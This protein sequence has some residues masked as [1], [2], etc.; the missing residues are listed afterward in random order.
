[1]TEHAAC[2]IHYLSLKCRNL[3]MRAGY[4]FTLFYFPVYFLGCEGRIST[5]LTIV[6]AGIFST[7]ATAS[8]TSSAPTFHELSADFGLSASPENSVFTLPGIIELTRTFSYR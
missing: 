3:G 4:F 5:R 8:A 1:M 2:Q 6:R 7:I